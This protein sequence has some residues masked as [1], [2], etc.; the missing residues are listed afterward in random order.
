MH[1]LS[2]GGGQSVVTK[3]EEAACFCERFVLLFRFV[4]TITQSRGVSNV[5]PTPARFEPLLAG[6]LALLHQLATAE[7][8]RPPCGYMAAKLAHNL[9][10][11]AEHPGVSAAFAIVLR[12]LAAQWSQRAAALL[13]DVD[14]VPPAER[15]SLLH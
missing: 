1:G 4:Y 2:R 12:R 7:S 9:E 8:A 15:A 11:L 14:P 10:H 13:Q 6:T 5:L 3:S